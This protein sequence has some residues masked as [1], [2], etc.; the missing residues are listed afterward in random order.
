MA[1]GV[2]RSKESD[3]M[4]WSCKLAKAGFVTLLMTMVMLC[5]SVQASEN[6]A[7]YWLQM[8]QE[9]SKND[10]DEQ[11]LK[12]YEKAIQ[13]DPEN[14]ISWINK[15]NVLCRLNKTSECNQSY[16]KALEIIDKTLT[17]HPQ[18][19]TLWAEKGLLLHN[20]G[21]PQEAVKAFSNATRINPEDE[22]S[23]KM[24]GV[25]LAS[26]LHRY[27]EAAEAFD[28]ALQINQNDAIVWN[29]KG[30]ALKAMGRQAEA[31]AVYA[32][33]VEL[34]NG[35][36]RIPQEFLI[37]SNIA[38]T[39]KDRF[40]ELRTGSNSTQN[41]S[42]WSLSDGE[43]HS[44]TIPIYA[45]EPRKRLRLHFGPGL[46]N[47]TDI[48]L[49]AGF[50]LNEINGNLTLK[51][52]TGKHEMFI[53]YWEWV[54]EKSPNR[55][56][57]ADYW[58]K[59]AN[60]L[61]LNGSTDDAISAYDR[62]LQIDPSN[63]TIWTRK[64]LE[65]A[66]SGRDNESLQASEK[67]LGILDERLKVNPQ[68]AEA[69]MRKGRALSNLGRQNESN[70]AHEMAVQIFNKS[71]Q[72]DPRNSSLWRSMA[73]SL[74]NLGRWDEALQ[75]L[76]RVTEIDPKNLDAW[77][78]K[79]E[80]LTLLS[81]TDESLEAFNKSLELIAQ[82][83]TKERSLVWMAKA[84]SL[85]YAD[86]KEESLTALNEVTE[87]YP[88]YVVAWKSKGY[89]LA[90]LG[91]PNESLAAYE[92]AI[93]IDPTDSQSWSE[94]GSQLVQ[95]KRYN[96]SLPAFER[97]LDLTAESEHKE[98][99]AAWLSIGDSLNMTGRTE[100]AMIAFRTALNESEDAIQS[101]GNDTKLLELKGRALLKMGRYEQALKAFEQAIAAT[102]PGSLSA[103][104]I[105]IGKGDALQAQGKNQDALDAYNHAIDLS[106]IYPDA[107]AGRGE[108]Q[109]SQG[110]VTEAS[111][112]FYVARKLGYKE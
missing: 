8:G 4:E 59:K 1:L 31:D 53:A 55:E 36:F 93:R 111:A 33:A 96:E 3:F 75:A 100:K 28:G 48:F 74:M 91:R 97:S 86:R 38:A 110:Q 81:R 42:N 72:K 2:C 40:I 34:G 67:A 39:G 57:T 107:W 84:Q 112:S 37:I 17:I 56:N 45:I 78:R 46:S 109:K 23:W 47:A 24:M 30:D 64:A 11:A 99:A 94:K 88:S 108:A 44:I 16:S 58:A 7:D 18:N 73:E 83:D 77:E 76:N 10:S 54:P 13:I 14:A 6:T 26:E 69:W 12:A 52:Q 9:L 19:S 92:E 82:N 85:S 68:D 21:A 71:I 95:L 60:D 15:A 20:V 49:N 27:D 66:I 80:F 32:R 62:A 79:G 43:N 103:P 106:P 5:V 89:I 87:L 35:S 25:I 61:I 98:R 50:T 70:Q 22:M 63:D 104:T 90:D 102:S 41:F 101:D 65:L 51:D 105:W 29:L